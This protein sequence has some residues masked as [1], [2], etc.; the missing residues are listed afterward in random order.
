MDRQERDPPRIRLL[1]LDPYKDISELHVEAKDDDQFLQFLDEAYDRVER[2]GAIHLEDASDLL[3]AEI[4]PLRWLIPRYIPEGLTLLVGT[5]KLGKSWLCLAIAE[6]CAS[7]RVVLGQSVRR[8]QAIYFALEDSK[9]RY[10]ERLRLLLG[11]QVVAAPQ[12]I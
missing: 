4:P 2:W 7:N 3:D 5:P 1:R 10:Q 6:A 8:C 9:R 11:V 12:A